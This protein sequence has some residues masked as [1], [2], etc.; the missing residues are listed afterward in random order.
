M[1]VGPEDGQLRPKPLGLLDY[2]I[3]E[4]WKLLMAIYANFM[5]LLL[6]HS[7]REIKVSVLCGLRTS[8]VN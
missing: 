6:Y 8:L 3:I 7:I 4:N 1:L 5:H 2:L